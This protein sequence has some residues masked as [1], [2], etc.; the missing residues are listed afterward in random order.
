M[1]R[2]GSIVA[3]EIAPLP[4]LLLPPLLPPQVAARAQRASVTSAE[5][6]RYEQYNERHGAKY[7]AA[8]GGAA[9]GDPTQQE[10]QGMEEDEEEW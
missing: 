6:V 5:V 3:I 8:P 10:G 7:V 9:G 1:R 2:R 4:P